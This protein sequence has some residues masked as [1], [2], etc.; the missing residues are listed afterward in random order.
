MKCYKNTLL[1]KGRLK[2]DL[3]IVHWEL[4]IPHKNYVQ[5]LVTMIIELYFDQVTFMKNM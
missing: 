2:L 1:R 5:K 3:A 4:A